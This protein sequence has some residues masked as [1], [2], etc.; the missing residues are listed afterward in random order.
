MKSF[1]CFATKKKEDKNQSRLAQQDYGG[2]GNLATGGGAGVSKRLLTGVRAVGSLPPSQNKP[3]ALWA[4]GRG[5]VKPEEGAST[6]NVPSATRRR[7]RKVEG[8]DG[9]ERLR[10]RT[11][12]PKPDL[13]SETPDSFSLF[14]FRTHLSKRDTFFL[15]LVFS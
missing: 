9:D 6:V 12:Q 11:F 15:R 4:H 3:T 14:V 10:R 13:S 2:R 8:E 7:R 1:R 5:E